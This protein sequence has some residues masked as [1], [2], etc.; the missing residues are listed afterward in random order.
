[1]VDLEALLDGG[2]LH[3]QPGVHSFHTRP[4]RTFAL[5][6]TEAGAVE[7]LDPDHAARV[8]VH[9]AIRLGSDVPSGTH[10]LTLTVPAGA[11]TWLRAAIETTAPALLPQDRAPRFVMSPGEDAE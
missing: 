4:V 2:T 8:L 9:G 1:G 10:R 5:P 11:G 3:R 6:A 7:L